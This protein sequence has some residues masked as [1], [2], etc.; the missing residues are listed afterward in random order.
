MWGWSHTYLGKTKGE[1]RIFAALS[2]KNHWMNEDIP[3]SCCCIVKSLFNERKFSHWIQSLQ[4]L[5]KDVTVQHHDQGISS[6]FQWFLLRVCLWCKYLA[7]LCLCT[8]SSYSHLAN[9]KKCDQYRSA[10]HWFL[11][12]LRSKQRCSE[13]FSCDIWCGNTSWKLAY[14]PSDN[15]IYALWTKIQ[16]GQIHYTKLHTGQK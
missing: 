12:P 10:Q 6:F 3:L 8:V 16:T 1:T 5:N 9:I 2:K 15:Y 11:R 4:S 13:T 7:H 14:W